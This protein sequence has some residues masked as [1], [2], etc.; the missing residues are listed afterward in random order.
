MQV[1]FRKGLCATKKERGWT[2]EILAHRLGLGMAC[3]RR[4]TSRSI[5]REPYQLAGF[6]RSF[7]DD[8]ESE[9]SRVE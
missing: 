5:A 9:T 2:Q 8:A 7:Q 4:E 6:L 1:G 3:F